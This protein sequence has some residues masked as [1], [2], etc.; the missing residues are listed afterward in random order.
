MNKAT[1]KR[2][3]GGVELLVDEAGVRVQLCSFH[4]RQLAVDYDF[5]AITAQDLDV[6]EGSRLEIEF[7]KSVNVHSYDWIRAQ[8]S[9]GSIF[10]LNKKITV[11]FQATCT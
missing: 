3:Q 1:K 8:E 4:T 7:Q 6:S 5:L 11:A 10:T 2:Y 9:E